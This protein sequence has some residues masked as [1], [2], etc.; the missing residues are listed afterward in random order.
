[1]IAT[2]LAAAVLYGAGAAVE[3]RQAAAAPDSSAGRPRLLFLL[4]RQPLWLLGIA[5]QIGGFAAHAVALRSGPLATVQLL[6]SAEL[7][8]AVVIV[9]IWS[10]RPLDRASWAAALTVVAS[11]SAFLALTSSGH[12][13]GQPGHGAAMALGAIATGGAALAAAVAVLLIWVALW[14]ALGAWRTVNRDC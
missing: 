12:V 10:G 3:Q 13:A 11:V 6:V 9:R 7:V 8:V 2:A 1:M 5:V 14:F 4:A